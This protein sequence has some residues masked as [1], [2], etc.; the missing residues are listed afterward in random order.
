M[1][2]RRLQPNSPTDLHWGF[3]DKFTTNDYLSRAF[4]LATLATLAVA[5]AL[6]AGRGLDP[7]ARPAPHVTTVVDFGPVPAFVTQIVPR[8]PH[9]RP[10]IRSAL[11][12]IVPV[13]RPVDESTDPAA[14]NPGAST[15]HPS[16][17]TPAGPSDE[18]VAGTGEL[19]SIWPSPDD[20]IPVEREPVLVTMQAP[21]YPELAR[22]AHIDG[23]VLVRV[24]VGED[25][26]VHQAL[27]LQ[28]VLGLDDAALTAART[29]V[30]KPALQQERPVAV[31]I[32]I[33]IEF[34]LH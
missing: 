14:L 28:S 24:L 20:Y 4:L 23:T 26:F 16:D 10:P 1:S 7:L 19:A 17:S 3:L 6:H 34:Q 33:P 22:D 13:P 15:A 32:V 25:G 2:M 31:W 21:V 5:V 27:L 29:A 12:R 18:A 9:P 11:A 8:L 30:F